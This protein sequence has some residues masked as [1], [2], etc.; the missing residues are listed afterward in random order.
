MRAFSDPAEDVDKSEAFHA[1]EIYLAAYQVAV[2]S[3]GRD[4]IA[5]AK[6]EVSF[7]RLGSGLV[8]GVVGA[9]S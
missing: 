5:A 2:Y 7:P 6:S 9:D 3:G 4:E 8:G 1:D